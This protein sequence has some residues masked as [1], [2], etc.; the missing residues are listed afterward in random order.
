MRIAYIGSEKNASTGYIL[1]P[2]GK[3][4]YNQGTDGTDKA[5]REQAELKLL[6]G[7]VI[8]LGMPCRI[9]NKMTRIQSLEMNEG[10]KK[11]SAEDSHKNAIKV[12]IFVSLA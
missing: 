4:F 10:G 12:Q 8:Y 5:Q 9:T 11:N 1:Y 3:A 6:V 7:D 2:C